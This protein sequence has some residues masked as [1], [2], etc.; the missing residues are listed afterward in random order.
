MLQKGLG[1][2]AMQIIDSFHK[3]KHL[4]KQTVYLSLQ[5]DPTILKVRIIAA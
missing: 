4:S 3:Q 1:L 2:M 5:M